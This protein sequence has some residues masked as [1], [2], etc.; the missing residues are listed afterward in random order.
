MTV[1]QLAGTWFAL[2]V[3][4]IAWF[5][6]GPPERFGAAVLIL[7]ESVS[8]VLVRWG[9]SGSVYPNAMVIEC[10]WLLFIGVL[11]FRSGRWWPL[12]M[13]AALCLI[14]LT[15]LLKLTDTSLSLYAAMS[16]HVG[17]DYL[18]DLTLLLGVVE[19]WLAGKPAAGPA[20]WARADRITAA[21]SGMST[22]ARGA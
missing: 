21:R 16:A 6:G 20:A 3:Y 2:I 1:W 18:I 10:V 14:V 17:L 13:T 4:A 22:E 9:F 7:D 15:Y 8:L 19:R 11:A 12:V 5:R